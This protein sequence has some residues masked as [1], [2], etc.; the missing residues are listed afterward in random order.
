MV[1]WNS[2]VSRAFLVGQ[3][4]MMVVGRVRACMV[5]W[6]SGVARAFLGG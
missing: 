3:I 1:Q 2:G 5:Q 4:S 6:N